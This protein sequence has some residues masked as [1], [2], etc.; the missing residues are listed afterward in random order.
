MKLAV[1]LLIGGLAAG[2]ESPADVLGK[3]RSANS[4]KLADYVALYTSQFQFD[5]GDDRAAA[6]GLRAVWQQS[7]KSPLV[8]RAA[9][10]AAKAYT[11]LGEPKRGLETLRKHNDDLPQP[12][13]DIALAVTAEAAQDRAA[14]ITYY[15]RVY[16]SYPTSPSA[17]LAGEALARLNAQGGT[18]AMA[19]GRALKLMEANN[20][21]QAR[22]ELQVLIPM[23]TGAERDIARVRMGVAQYNL[24]DNAA[25][26]TYLSGLEGLAPEA[27]AERLFYGMQ[28]ARRLNNLGDVNRIL[29]Q[30]AQ[31][32][33]HSKWRAE[34]LTAAA[35]S[36]VVSNQP[37]LFEPLFIACANDL[38]D[39]PQA[40]E[41][42]W[43]VAFTE[44]M[45][46]SPTAG[47]WLKAHIQRY[48]KSD[49]VPAALYF[50]GRLAE[51]SSQPQAA[52]TYYERIER[53]FPNYY[54][55]MLVRQRLGTSPLQTVSDRRALDLTPNATAQFRLERARLLTAAG[56]DDLAD[57]ELR[58]GARIEDQ[59]NVLAMALGR[60]ATL[61]EMPERALR[62]M[63][64]YTPG[65]LQMPLDSAPIDYWKLVFPLPYREPLERFSKAEGLDP[66]LMAALI[67]QESE[68]D[69]NIVSHAR[70]YGLTQVLPS[71]GRDLARQLGVK[72]FSA[73]ML[74]RPELNLQ[75]GT[76]YLKSMLGQLDN[77]ME[78]TLAAYN[79]GKTRA[80]AWL[81]WYEYREPAEFVE[82]IPFNETR[83]YVQVVLRN[84]DIYR[85]L[86]PGPLTAAK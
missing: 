54:Y 83:N 34:A 10:L 9:L 37:E 33:P 31:Q 8:G 2:A 77:H 1:C 6:E 47:D 66:F 14:A 36:Y 16:Y 5:A 67:R 18:P 44:Y 48:P 81:K 53:E 79:A 12:D 22:T 20:N 56:L 84:A 64:R 74:F 52:R 13:G 80:V 28:C 41:C 43:R 78:A 25:A 59:P 38:P 15:Q 7:P 73:N 58:F 32:Y 19:L 68:F 35:N 39:S 60:Y 46:R 76:H 85:R 40:P 86:Y 21:K 57:V 45:R 61:R 70:A 24:R 23:L 63:K 17:L 49:K 30:L 11:R 75:F 27:D 55:A 69:K 26:F 62:Y 4:A 51:Q 71:T 42:H 29:G 82:S 3:L 50:L 65:Y 72:P